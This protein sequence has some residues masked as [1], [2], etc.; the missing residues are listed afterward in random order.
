MSSFEELRNQLSN[1]LSV[2]RVRA[3]GRLARKLE[4]NIPD[5]EIEYMVNS[6]S[7]EEVSQRL[8]RKL[9]WRR[10]WAR[11]VSFIRD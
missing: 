1:N 3:Y 6:L 5:S 4:L 8:Q 10:A 2:L 7:D 9:L 11:A